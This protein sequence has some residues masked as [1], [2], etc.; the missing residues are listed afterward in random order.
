M[1]ETAR[2]AVVGAG[3]DEAARA[4]RL[5]LPEIAVEAA[6]DLA[7]YPGSW[8]AV[9]VV[10]GPDAPDPAALT[11][12]LRVRGEPPPVVLLADAADEAAAIA[13]IDHGAAAL[14]P[15]GQPARLAAAVRLTMRETPAALAAMHERIAAVG[16]FAAGLAHELNNPL[17][18]LIFNIEHGQRRC[19]SELEE[20][21]EAMACAERLRQIIRDLRVFARPEDR[22]SGAIDV[23]TLLGSAL[24]P[25]ASEVR[26]R[27][28]LRLRYGDV[29]R[30]HG[31]D[32]HLA[33][34]LLGLIHL[35][36]KAMPMDQS[37]SLLLSTSV[38]ADTVR[39]DIAVENERP[40]ATPL[41]PTRLAACRA[42]LV[43]QGASLIVA[44]FGIAMRVH[45]P[46]AREQPIPAAP[47]AAVRPR[48]AVIDGDRA[49]AQ[50]V[51]R[52]LLREH[53]VELF[54]DA[55]EALSRLETGERFDVIVCDLVPPGA[56][57]PELH[58]RVA[59]IDP[60]QAAR[61]IF[62]TGGVFSPE[63][64]EFRATTP[65]PVL[66]K[67]FGAHALTAAIAAVRAS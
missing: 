27:G 13:W 3:R 53:A 58:R 26:R 65:N 35:A 25:L 60:A 12:L 23:H 18:A 66:D 14:V 51:R 57:G 44:D 67:P 5:V 39:I 33:N 29:P 22:A 64:E 21:R 45:L 59:A 7:T 61:I 62:M 63:L 8:R 30:V 15:A 41:D 20:L 42:A 17:A 38:D 52:L 4:L 43:E 9:V 46:I 49:V 34:T 54:H 48:V 10:D 31:H 2:V 11:T 16:L 55:R 37:G 36:L 32:A 19:G 47:H 50:M 24:Q 40:A 56:P 6:E 28:A 1:P